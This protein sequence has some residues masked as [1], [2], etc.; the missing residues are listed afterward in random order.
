VIVGVAAAL[1][2]EICVKKLQK[3]IRGRA[4]RQKFCET[5]AP[6]QVLAML[7]SLKLTNLHLWV[8]I[9]TQYTY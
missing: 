1:V 3:F 5:L 9:F 4:Q 8:Q 6:I 7:I 2:L